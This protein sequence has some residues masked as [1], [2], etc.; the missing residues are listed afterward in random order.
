MKTHFLRHAVIALL[1]VVPFLAGAVEVYAEPTATALSRPLAPLGGPAITNN[2]LARPVMLYEE[3]P[4]DPQG[5]RAAGSV[6]WSTEI[7]PSGT[8]IMPQLVLRADINIPDRKMEITWKLRRDSDLNGSTSHTAEL[9]FKL[10]P[11]FASG[12]IFNVPGIWM[13]PA[14]PMQGTALYGRAVKVKPGYFLIGLSNA[15]ADRERNIQLLKDRSVIDI[16]IVYNNNWRA[17]L[18]FEKGTPGEQAFQQTF[19]AWEE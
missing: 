14:I 4:G 2:S 8:G 10:P 13:K 17:I 16:P 12:G 6:V 11:D 15:P 19:A 5:R 9:R 1:A 3:E 18:Q 7:A